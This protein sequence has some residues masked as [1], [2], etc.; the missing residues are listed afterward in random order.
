MISMMIEDLCLQTEENIKELKIETVNDVRNSKVYVAR[1]SDEMQS[2]LKDLRNF[3]YNNFY[4]S[5][6]VLHD[7]LK[8][9][10]MIKELFKFY[11]DYPDH[12]PDD[13]KII[14]DERIEMVVKDYIAGMTDRF[15][16]EEYKRV[17]GD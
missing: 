11:I 16:I 7:S 10:E 9:K 3:L 5:T 1:F 15:L 14:R 13:F 2:M 17:V 8:G 4:M 6:T 12:I